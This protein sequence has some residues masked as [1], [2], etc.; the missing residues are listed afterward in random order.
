MDSMRGLN[1]SLSH[2]AERS[3]N[4]AE[5]PE[6]LIDVFK[7]A[8]L[9]VTK[10]YKTSALLESKARADGYQDCLDDLLGFLDK[11]S[12][13][14]SHG[15]G[16]RIR[17][18]AN[19]RLDGRDAGNQTGES[20][21]EA[22]KAE[23]NSSSEMTKESSA[24]PQP[25]PATTKPSPP[26]AAPVASNDQ[27]PSPVLV[28]TQDTFTFQSSYPYPNIA[29]LDLSDAKAHNGSSHP[30]RT[31]RSRLHGGPSRPGARTQSHLGRGAGNKRKMD[32]DEFFGGCF[33]GKD[34]FGNG[35]KRNRH[36]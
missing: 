31:G 20:E 36:A 34:P 9:S 4:Q 28:P 19:E 14:L 24:A 16:A 1:N 27:P 23:A 15:E 10:L 11:E 29:K 7:A 32:F 25:A 3:A 12:L 35:S 33:G 26:I 18:W 8:A 17:Q 22:D 13:G 30:S 21:D 2:G 6:Q 5:S